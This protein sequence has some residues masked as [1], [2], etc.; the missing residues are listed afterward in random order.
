[1]SKIIILVLCLY[2]LTACG[3][4]DGSVENGSNVLTPS[5]L[6]SKPSIYD[7]EHVVVKGL[8]LHEVENSAL[9]DSAS[10]YPNGNLSRC[11][12]VVYSKSISSSLDKLNHRMVIIKGVFLKNFTGPNEVFL[13]SCNISGISVVSV[14]P[15]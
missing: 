14:A 5:E 6:N 15:M 8:L 12:T 3:Y 1:M 13:G 11:V 9:W 7:H 10:S 2:M 4:I